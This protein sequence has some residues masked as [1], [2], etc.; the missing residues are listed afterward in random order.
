MSN[1]SEIPTSALR[2]NELVQENSEL[3]NQPIE[4]LVELVPR[5]N[6]VQSDIEKFKESK[7]PVSVEMTNHTNTLS[8]LFQKGNLEY[9][10]IIKRLYYQIIINVFIS[11]SKLIY[12]TTINFLIW[13]KETFVKYWRHLL[14]ILCVL[15]LLIAIGFI[16]YLIYDSLVQL[17]SW[18]TNYLKQQYERLLNAIE[19]IQ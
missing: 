3:I 7:I 18:S 1:L 9:S 2:L 10:R 16:I 5:V 14:V 15:A 17:W 4:P 13:C 19:T 8:E 12:K 11:V 6:K